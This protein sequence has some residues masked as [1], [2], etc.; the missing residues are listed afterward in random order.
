VAACRLRWS[1]ASPSSM[2]TS[3]VEIASAGIILGG[4]GAS[5]A[6][7]DATIRGTSTVGSTWSGS[8]SSTG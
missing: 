8:S 4:D 7:E 1:K 3:A 6:S 5:N 2:V